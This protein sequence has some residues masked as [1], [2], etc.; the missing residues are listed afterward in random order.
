MTEEQELEADDNFVPADEP[1]SSRAVLAA[2]RKAEDAFR[3]WQTQCDV[4][5][6]IYSRDG[7]D[8]AG[9][10]LGMEGFSWQDAALDLFWASYE[11]LKPA[12][13]ARAPQPVVSPLFKDNRQLFNLTAEA[14]ERCAVSTFKRTGINDVMLGLRDDLIFTSRAAPWVRYETEDGKKKVCIVHK[15]RR[16]FLH[17]PA[18]N[19]S[20]VGW[21]AG[22]EWLTRKDMRKRFHK[23]SGDAYK[24]ASYTFRR[25][26][27]ENDHD[28]EKR[29][30]SKKCKVWEVWHKADNK[31]YWVT[32]GVD[33]LLDEGEPHLD[34]ADF[35]P[36]PKPAYATLQRRSLV[37]SPDY[38]RYAIHFDKISELT[39]RI[40]ALLDDVRMKGLIPAGGDVGDAVEELIRSDDDRLLIP[41]PAASLLGN[42][43]T[44]FVM[45]L[46]LA[47]LATAIQGLIDARNQL[48]QDFFQLSGI[49]DIMRGATDADETLGAQ[50]LK[51][52]YGSVRV[53]DKSAEL[54]RVAAD[55][56]KIAAEIIADKFSQ[57]DILEMSLLEIPTK[58]EIA[59]RV[60]E[61][62]KAATEEL[63][64]L[65][66]K[67]QEAAAKA[68]QG[69]QQVDPGQAQ[70]QFQQAQQQ[71]LA[72]YAPMLA[73]AEQ[74]VPVE[75]VMKLLR[76]DRARTFTFEI[77][78]SS[79][80]L[81]DE[82]QE[83][84]SRNEFMTV[85]TESISG[86][87]SIIA[88]GEPAVKLWGEATKFQLAPYRAGRQLEGAIDEFIDAA[89]QM[90]QAMSAANGQSGEGEE[91]A[92]AN[93][94][95]ADAEM[96]KARAA[97]A[98]VEAKAALDK[99]EMQRK[100]MEM[101]QK[102]QESEFKAQAEA[103]KLRQALSAEQTKTALIEAQ[104]NKLTAETAAILNK[105]GLDVRQQE[106][107][108]YQA[109]T[110]AQ[111]QQA[112]QQMRAEES[113]TD[114]DFRERG[115]ERADRQQD[116]SEQTGDRQLT[117]AERQAQQ[118]EG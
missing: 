116:F 113:A 23:T 37:P 63:E 49:S 9:R 30:S 25:E 82:L 53:R 41:V 6:Q 88:M 5:D 58:A 115:E 45:W 2:L 72:K 77:E 78:S 62:E 13:Y 106:L 11:I 91:L 66:K 71:V 3:G 85:L 39:R 93:Q 19:W 59:K 74:Q 15:D 75:D 26:R 24:E 20:A 96:V 117:L 109:S 31:V 51:S 73:E 34:L 36:C 104:V 12:V 46:P 67:A 79:T 81:I 35:F 8:A 43:A 111:V 70:Q 4:I 110:Q 97:T 40:Y 64:G 22:G 55:C 92:K 103:E 89:P 18:R 32:D 99:A 50:Q 28:L 61:I 27:D 56:V 108:E 33:V 118:G 48:I 83:K 17:E 98:S 84:Q 76:D 1:K 112:D 57:D 7:Y 69:G 102:A 80:I 87:A 21:V 86:L 38:E 68:Q 60:K 107:S 47:E 94:T 101:Q 10:A 16:D 52:Q 65:G 95:L 54:Q 44:S 114:R 42:G 90:A 14:L 105:I 100:L 29:A